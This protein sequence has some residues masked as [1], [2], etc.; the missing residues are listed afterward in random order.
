MNVFVPGTSDRVDTGSGSLT[1]ECV[2]TVAVRAVNE[3]GLSDPAP[4]DTTATPSINKSAAI[5]S[6]NASQTTGN[7]SPNNNDAVVAKQS[8]TA[9]SGNTIGTLQELGGG[10]AQTFCGGAPCAAG[11]IVFHKLTDPTDAARY[12]V[13]IQYGKQVTFGTGQK[14]VYFDD[15]LPANE[16]GGDAFTG[17][18]QIP[19]CPTAKK[20][21]PA[22]VLPDACIVKLVANTSKNPGVLVQVSVDG[23]IIDP[24]TA[25]RK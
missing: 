24:M 10:Q 13:E 22:P 21:Q 6:G 1:N 19:T 17:P 20:G 8:S 5:L 4:S 7:G 15:L 25:T 14:R 3:V 12:I 9:F 11:T 16:P 18:K 23:N 2:Y